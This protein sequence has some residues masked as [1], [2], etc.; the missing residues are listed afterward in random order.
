MHAAQTNYA[1]APMRTSSGAYDGDDAIMHSAHS[2]HAGDTQRARAR[3]QQAAY[4]WA[5][6]EGKQRSM[7]EQGEQMDSLNQQFQN[8]VA[9]DQ[10]R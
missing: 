6:P 5:G 1:H 9:V 8:G 2:S 7:R 10:H 4:G 3:Q